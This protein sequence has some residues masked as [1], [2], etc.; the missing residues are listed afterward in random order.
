METGEYDIDFLRK[1]ALYYYEHVRVFRLYLAGAMTVVPI[2][3]F[4]VV[5]SE[6]IADEFGVR[7]Y[8]EP[9]VDGHPELFRRFMRSLGLTEEDWEEESSGKNLLEGVA[10]YKDVHYGLFWSGLA[11]ETVGAVIFGMERTTPHRH[12]KVL[13]GLKRFSQRTGHEI[14]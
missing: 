4:Q 6:I 9:D 7:L 13:E 5:L 2:E 11:A 8:D 14:D 12:S 10:H 3:A 1:Y